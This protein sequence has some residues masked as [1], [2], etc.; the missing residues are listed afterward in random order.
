MVKKVLFCVVPGILPAASSFRMT[1]VRK[2]VLRRAILWGGAGK[3]AFFFWGGGMRPRLFLRLKNRD[4]QKNA[5]LR[6]QKPLRCF[7][8]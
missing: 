7:V 8:A 1:A 4:G 6:V 2:N 3:R 5:P